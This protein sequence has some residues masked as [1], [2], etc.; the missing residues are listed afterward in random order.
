MKSIKLLGIL[1]LACCQFSVAQKEALIDRQQE[2]LQ[3][4]SARIA[5][6]INA[7]TEELKQLLD[8]DLTY[9]HTTGWTETKA[10]YLETIKSG[11]I[12]YLQF[13]PR[14]VEVRIYQNTAVLTGLVDVNLGRTDF[15][16]RFLEV[17]RRVDGQWKLTAW[18]SV[19]NKVD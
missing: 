3:A 18:Q 10:G 9:S 13:S 4:Q 8:E 19:I 5:A 12:D 14:D 6:M 16:I 11:K 1:L 15:T 17:Q 2:V 7:D